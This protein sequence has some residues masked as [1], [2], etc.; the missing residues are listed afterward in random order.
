M[1]FF[2][3]LLSNVTQIHKWWSL[4][5][6]EEEEKKRKRSAQQLLRGLMVQEWTRV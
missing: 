4:E 2:F 1:L 5:E 6:G 3:Q